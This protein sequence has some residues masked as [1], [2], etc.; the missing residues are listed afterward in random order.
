MHLRVTKLNL[1]IFTD[2]TKQN[3]PPGSYYHPQKERIYHFPQAVVFEN[4]FLPGRN[5][6]RC[7]NDQI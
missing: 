1:F 2:A 7:K 3:S 4:L 5:F 6:N